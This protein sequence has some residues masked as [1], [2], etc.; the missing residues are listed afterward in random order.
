MVETVISPNEISLNS[1]RYPIR[2]QVSPS[3]ISTM[4]GKVTFGDYSLADEQI[5]SSFIM[6]DQRGGILVEEMDESIHLDRA[7]WSTCNLGFKGHIVLPRLATELTPAAASVAGT[8]Y[9]RPNAAGQQTELTPSAGANY[10]AVDE[11]TTDDATTYVRQTATGAN[12]IEDLYRT[13]TVRQATGTISKVTICF[14]ARSSDTVNCNI[15]S[16]VKTHGTAYAGA[17]KTFNA[18]NTWEDFTQEYT[19]NP[20]TS[21]AWTWAELGI[22]QIG[23]QHIAGA[24]ADADTVD[25]TQ[26]Y[27]KVEFTATSSV[28]ET[29]R[30]SAAG[31]ECNIDSETGDACP[32]HYLNVDEATADDDTTIVKTKNLSYLRDFYNIEDH[33]TGARII[34]HITVYAVC[35]GEATIDQASLKIAIKSGTGTGAPDTA[36]EATAEEITTSYVAYSNEWATNPATSAAWT[37]DEVDKLQIGIALQSTNSGPATSTYCTQVYVEVETVDTDLRETI[38]CNFNNKKYMARGTKLYAL[39]SAGSGYDA[40]KVN[41]TAPITYLVAFEDYLC[42][43]CGSGANYWYMDVWETCTET[44]VEGALYGIVWD[45]KVF[46]IDND[47]QLSHTQTPNSTTPTWTANGKIELAPSSVTSLELYR[48][49]DANYIIYAGTIQGLWAHDYSN[50][51]WLETELALPNHPTCGKG[52]AHWREGLYISAGLDIH[53]YI[54][55]RT[56]TI[57][58]M[59]LDREDGLPALRGGEIVK[60]LKGYNELFAAVDSTYEGAT[61]RSTVMAYDGKGWQCFWMAGANNL[62]IHDIIVSSDSDYRLWIGAGTKIYWIPLQRSLRNPKKVSGFTYDSA[63]IHI[64]PWFDGGWIGNKLALSTKVFCN[65]SAADAIVEVSYRIDHANTDILTG[66]TSLGTIAGAGDGVETEYTFGTNAVG[67]AF[68]SIQFS[69][70]LARG[71]TNTLSPDVIYLKFKYLKLLDSKWGWNV[72]VDCSKEHKSNTPLQ[73]IANL[74][75]ATETAT[76]LEFTFRDE[77][78]G[79]YTNYVKV[80]NAQ[81]LQ[82]T[83]SDWRGTYSLALVEP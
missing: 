22:L 1:V 42:I 31:D 58:P 20:N 59:G 67:V 60:L 57:A 80:A 40:V 2:G 63:G 33:S 5:A 37:W 7:W 24:G 73:L 61:S 45:S 23:T 30:P 18:A 69:F 14:R 21:V 81:S 72:T 74:N 49:A 35:K 3:L 47:G 66:W 48:D 9:L 68:K 32:N 76:L 17:S 71:A 10:A 15:K 43:Y 52:L 16:Y 28:V 46:K 19:T 44:D 29:L 78:G 51:K 55:A 50:A 62:E 25:N 38:F 27:A 41:F 11:V 39:N 12:T 65:D 83:G 77:S 13:R 53:K 8:I 75:A 64:T 82:Q 6:S 56:A 34:D 26:V 79:T 70:D 4:P 36:D 54:A